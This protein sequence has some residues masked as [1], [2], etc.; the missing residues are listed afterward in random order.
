MAPFSPE[1]AQQHQQQWTNYLGVPVEYENSIGM[2]L[3]PKPELVNHQEFSHATAPQPDSLRHC[4]EKPC[5]VR[6]ADGFLH[7]RGR[8]EH[9]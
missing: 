9:L 4:V 6:P 8:V 3:I 5:G 2:K 1:E 7:I